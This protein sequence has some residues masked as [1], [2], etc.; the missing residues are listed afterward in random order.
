MS[1]FEPLTIGDVTLKNRIAVSPMSQYAATDGVA[2]EWQIVHLGRFAMGGAGLVFTEAVGVEA[3]GRRTPGDLGLWQDDQIAPMAR[4]AETIRMFGAVPAIQLGHAGRKGSERRPWHRDHWVD[5]EDVALRG[6][7][8]WQTI[9]PTDEPFA[10]DWHTPTVMTESD[11]AVVIEAFGAA[12]ARAK[13]AGF[14][15]LEIYGAH[16]FLLHQFLSPLGNRR[17]VEYGGSAENRMRL[18]LAVVDS[19]RRAWPAPRPLFYRLSAVDWAE[20]GLSLAHTIPFAAALKQHGVD[21]VD[22]SS[23]GIG[24][25]AQRQQIPVGPLF[26]VPFAQAIRHDAD[27]K[28]MAVGF[29][30]TGAEANSLIEDGRADI[31]A[32]G[33]E[34]LFNPN[35]PHH[36]AREL[37]VDLEYRAWHP[38]FGWW[39]R[40]RDRAL[41][42]TKGTTSQWAAA[43]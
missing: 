6:E 26:Q 40:N 30:R 24:G 10:P 22:C 7:A 13:D 33:R 18:P 36:A 43:G 5:D 39:L 25:A 35:W 11:I 9:A 2:D 3:R 4:V 19:V 31:A 14:E 1:L 38:Q 12:A 42:A 21:V 17:T 20:G 27:I 37:G 34:I 23:G 41:N 15:V 28:T 32:I 8:P 16:G 29:I